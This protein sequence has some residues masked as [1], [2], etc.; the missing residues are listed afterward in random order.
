[1]QPAHVTDVRLEVPRLQ[2]VNLWSLLV[3]CVIMLTAVQS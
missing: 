3:N 1:L 2:A